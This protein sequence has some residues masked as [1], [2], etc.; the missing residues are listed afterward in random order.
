[1]GYRPVSIAE[2]VQ[3]GHFEINVEAAARRIEIRKLN[4]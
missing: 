1:V 4:L 2:A 3:A